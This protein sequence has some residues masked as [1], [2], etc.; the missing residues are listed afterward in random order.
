MYTELQ[1]RADY[2]ILQRLIVNLVQ[3][4]VGQPSNVG[5]AWLNDAQNL[6]RKM[7]EHLVSLRVLTNAHCVEIDQ[8]HSFEFIDH[9]SVK[10]V[11]RAAFETYLVFF[12][13][14]GGSDPSL[15]EFRHKIWRYGGLADRQKSQLDSSKACDILAAEKVVMDHLKLE[16]EASSHLSAYANTAAKKILKGEWRGGKSWADLS[17]DAGFHESY[18]RNI[19]GYLCGYSHASYISVLQVGQ[20]Q[21]LDDQQTLASVCID[22]GL[23]LMANF[24]RA[25]CKLFEDTKQILDADLKAKAAV[26]RWGFGP[27]AWAKAIAK[28]SAS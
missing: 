8:S 10:V 21:S 5:Q 3:S 15:S 22:I 7:F 4:R 2:T 18:F 28:R 27:D 24:V 9:S 19:Y 6:A 16:I 23:V 13:I 14:F 26:D 12:F 20:A 11:T 25:Y 17:T 1:K